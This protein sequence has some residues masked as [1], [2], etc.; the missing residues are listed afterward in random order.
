M[1]TEVVQRLANRLAQTGMPQAAIQALV[2]D[3]D[4]GPCRNRHPR[5]VAFCE[6][7]LG[8]HGL[9][10]SPEGYDE[11]TGLHMASFWSAE[12]KYPSTS[13]YTSPGSGTPAGMAYAELHGLEGVIICRAVA[14]DVI[15]LHVRPA[16]PREWS[17]WLARVNISPDAR[18]PGGGEVLF[19][20]GRVHGAYVSLVGH[21]TDGFPCGQRRRKRKKP[22]A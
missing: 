2:D 12:S 8:H 15:S 4:P 5:G 17:A 13:C 21:Q 14:D 6:L 18:P 10:M 19:A 3:T 20:R 7:N 16:S 1:T 9:H 11:R 22:Q